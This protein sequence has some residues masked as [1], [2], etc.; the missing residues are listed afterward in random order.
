MVFLTR[1]SISD[2]QHAISYAITCSLNIYTISFQLFDQPCIVKLIKIYCLPHHALLLPK[3]KTVPQDPYWTE[4]ELC[5]TL[6][7]WSD[8]NLIYTKMVSHREMFFISFMIFTVQVL[9][10][11]TE[12]NQVVIT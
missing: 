6:T 5:H 12:E 11:T 7:E 8:M 2:A 1:P 4:N 10:T 9:T 3:N